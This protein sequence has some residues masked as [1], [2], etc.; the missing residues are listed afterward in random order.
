MDAS[1]R[2]EIDSC[3]REL[4]ELSR[5]LDTISDDVTKSIKGIN[6]KKYTN[7]IQSSAKKYRRAADKLSKIK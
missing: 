1:L 2:R 3:I 7:A 6:T 4:R 5:Q